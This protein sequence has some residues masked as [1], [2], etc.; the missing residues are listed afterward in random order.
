MHNLDHHLFSELHILNNYLK[1]HEWIWEFETLW[2]HIFF[3]VKQHENHM[4]HEFTSYTIMILLMKF[5][6]KFNLMFTQISDFHKKKFSIFFFETIWKFKNNPFELI[7]I[8]IDIHVFSQKY[9]IWIS[10]KRW[11]YKSFQKKKLVF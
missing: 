8:L 6:N 1:I 11:W 5:M 9:C 2:K 10:E 7:W 4:N 3:I